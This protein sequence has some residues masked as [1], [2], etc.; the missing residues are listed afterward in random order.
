VREFLAG[1]GLAAD[2]DTHGLGGDAPD[3][4][5]KWPAWGE[6]KKYVDQ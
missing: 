4:L 1:A 3:F 6:I 2:Q 5:V